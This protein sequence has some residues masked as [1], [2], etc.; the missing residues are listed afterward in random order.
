MAATK[1]TAAARSGVFVFAP[2]S[3]ITN[4]PCMQGASITSVR[5]RTGVGYGLREA[6]RHAKQ[7]AAWGGSSREFAFAAAGCLEQC[8]SNQEHPGNHNCARDITWQ[9]C[10]HAYICKLPRTSCRCEY[11]QHTACHHEASRHEI[12]CVVLVWECEE[13]CWFANQCGKV[14]SANKGAGRRHE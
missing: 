6:S 11:E 7:L 4:C 12:N 8:Q 1:T 2:L 9:S 5:C 10:T 14:C 13:R 3:T